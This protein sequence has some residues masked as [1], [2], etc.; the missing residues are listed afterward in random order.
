MKREKVEN[1]QKPGGHMVKNNARKIKKKNKQEDES[2]CTS[3][4]FRMSQFCSRK[5]VGINGQ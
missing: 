1:K 2:V 4:L 3:Y 5:L